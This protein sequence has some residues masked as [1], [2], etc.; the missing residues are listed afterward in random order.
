MNLP[1]RGQIYVASVVATGLIVIGHC[2]SS[3]Y[4]NPVSY[5][6]VF[7]A[8]LTL[9]TG[10]FTVKVPGIPARISVSETFV[11]TSVLLF[12]TCA[13]TVTVALDTLVATLVARRR[14]QAALRIL[15]NLA[16]AAFS[17]WVAGTAF[18]LVS[19]LGPLSESPATLPE[20]LGPLV[21]MTALYFLMNSGLVAFALAFEKGQPPFTIW[22]RNFLWLSVNYFGGAS[23]AAL[24]VS[25]TR[26]VDVTAFSIIVPLVLISYLTYKTSLGRVEDANKHVEEMRRLH[27]STIET[28]ATAI[29][30]KDQVTHGH[31]RRVQQHTLGL[32]R[33]IG[34]TDPKQLSAIEAAALLHDLGKLVI[35][36][37]ILNKPG[38]LTP[39]EFERMKLHAG[40]GADIL[41]SIQFPYPVVPIVRHHHEN[42][43]GTGY[44]DGLKGTQIPL[45]ARIL[46]VVDCFD[47][48]TSDRPYRGRLSDEDAIG[49]LMARRG[50]MYDPLVVDVFIQVKDE[51]AENYARSLAPQPEPQVPSRERAPRPVDPVVSSPRIASSDFGIALR[52]VLTSIQKELQS[53]IVALFLKDPARDEISVVDAVG[54]DAT[55]I[56]SLR[57]QVGERVSGW[58]VANASPILNADS[59]LELE[60]VFSDK[61]VCLSIPI[62]VNSQ[63]QGALTLFSPPGATFGQ[64]SVAFVESVAK[65]FDA[66][67]LKDLLARELA[68]R[69]TTE[70]ARQPTVH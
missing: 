36:E 52:T 21:V 46:S 5:E 37:H 48:L 39:G 33:A 55:R 47:A 14:P 67:P 1:V 26:S 12:G 57:L 28:L 15:F 4:A 8:G 38:R 32:A 54:P 53:S 34:V 66:P 16:S 30:A 9:L 31:I 56:A 58:V 44:P 35:P 42:W 65:S 45:G 24:L 59:H 29:D 61:R 70:T 6:W 69:P 50:V 40:V 23:V 63:V 20:I 13:G 18:T 10:S 62:R 3:L 60:N 2:I 64:A 68:P 19:G 43:D 49:I 22:R 17:I 41:S 27:L 51:L 11:F 7:L 25:Y